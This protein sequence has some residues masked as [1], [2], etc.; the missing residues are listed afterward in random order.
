MSHLHAYWMFFAGFLGHPMTALRRVQSSVD[1]WPSLNRKSPKT[2]WAAIACGHNCAACVADQKLQYRRHRVRHY[3]LRRLE[4]EIQTGCDLSTFLIDR[5]A[6]NLRLANYFY[7]YDW[8]DIRAIPRCSFQE[9][10]VSHM[11]FWWRYLSVE[12]ESTFNTIS[13][14]EMYLIVLKRFLMVR[15]GKKEGT[16]QGRYINVWLDQEKKKIGIILSASYA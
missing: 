15:A 5:C 3:S 4:A 6:K 16:G 14:Q 10:C 12:C 9:L 1:L 7:W 2:S 13:V 8:H 11:F